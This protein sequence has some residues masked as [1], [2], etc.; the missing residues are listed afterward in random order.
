[1]T[2]RERFE[3]W[4]Q[5]DIYPFTRERDWH[6]HGFRQLYP[7]EYM[8]GDVQEKWLVWQAA[9]SAAEAATARRCAEW[10]NAWALD[11]DRHENMLNSIRAEFPGAFE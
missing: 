11:S 10:I 1:M 4:Y 2:S 3:Q 7:G 9:E 6:I 5:G 8:S